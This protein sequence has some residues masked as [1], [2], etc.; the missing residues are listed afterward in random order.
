MRTN[1]R[2]KDHGIIY[3]GELITSNLKTP[4]PSIV[5]LKPEEPKPI[6]LSKLKDAAI[7]TST[8]TLYNDRRES[9]EM[10]PFYQKQLLN[11]QER[12]NE[13]EKTQRAVLTDITRISSN[14]NESFR[15]DTQHKHLQDNHISYLKDLIRNQ[16]DQ[17]QSVMYQLNLNREAMNQMMD[18]SR[19]KYQEQQVF[20]FDLQSRLKANEKA[21][22]YAKEELNSLRS[23]VSQLRMTLDTLSNQFKTN[24]TSM[25][26][27]QQELDYTLD[28]LI[29]YQLKM[30]QRLSGS[31]RTGDANLIKVGK[32]LFDFTTLLKGF[33]EEQRQVL[34]REF[35]QSLN[36]IK[37]EEQLKRQEIKAKY[38]ELQSQ[39]EMDELK[40]LNAERLV[41]SQ[42]EEKLRNMTEWTQSLLDQR[43]QIQNQE[44]EEIVKTVMLLKATLLSRKQMEQDQLKLYMEMLQSSK[45]ELMTELDRLRR[46][47]ELIR[48]SKS[49]LII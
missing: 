12:L 34:K 22:E 44:N 4:L 33:E 23:E 2:P 46:E 47:I 36:V 10:D 31:T 18:F 15:E 30:D 38:N 1:Y 19:Q 45:Q 49:L 43:F 24:L 6:S 32:V 14:L 17:T 8:E 29:K 35:E 41:E 21:V 16:Q 3:D 28:D 48:G 27:K 26:S 5:A 42:V 39:L 9:V 40:I 37:E 13:S 20:I 7:E 25:S 11:M